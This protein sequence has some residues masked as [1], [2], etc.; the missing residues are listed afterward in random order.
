MQRLNT[1]S[2][3][4][5]QHENELSGSVRR[6]EAQH[7]QTVASLEKKLERTIES[8]N[9]LDNSLN[10]GPSNGAN[11]T[12]DGNVAM[13][14][15]ERLEELDKQRQRAQDAKFLI[16]CW[17]EVSEKGRLSTLEDVRR[18]GG[19]DGKVRCAHI[20]RQL[21]KL[22]QR[23]DDKPPGSSGGKNGMNGAPGDRT[24]KQQTREVIEKF[25]EM[26]EK[27]LL[28]QFD[29]HYRKQNFEGM[30]ECAVALRDFSD[31]ASV[32][33][34]FVNQHQFFI[35]RSQL[36]TE[37]VG[38]D[39]EILERLADPDAE[40]PGV[41][42]SLQSL[43]DE[44]RLVVQEESFIIKRAFPYYDE[45]LQ[46]FLQ[47][48]F[49]QSI[50]QRLEMVLE[51]ANSISS[52]AF[53]RTLHS[54]RS[55]IGALVEELKSHGLTEHP[56]P[57]S[58]A[59]VQVLDQQLEDMFVPYFVIAS[60]IE[61]ERRNLE[62]LYSSLLFK[63]TT[64][65]S[66]R[67]KLPTT[68]MGRLGERGKELMTSARDAYMDRLDST[69]LPPSQ[70]AML[71]RV[72]GLKAAD[73]DRKAEIEVSEEDGQLSLGNAKR[74]LK[75]LAEG[76]GRGL[77][78]SGGND[79]PKEAQVLLGLLLTHMGEIYLETA[80]V[81]TDELAVA[82]ESARTEPDLSYLVSLRTS[83][84]ILHLL[85]AS[86]TTMLL[87][88]AKP[89]LTIRRDIDKSTNASMSSLETKISTILHRSLD[90]ALVWVSKLLQ[91]Q[92]KT[93]F[94]PREEDM[95]KSFEMLQTPTCLSI[96][97]FL[98]K[99]ARFA[100]S[101][102]DGANLS[103][104]LADLALG[105]RSLLLEHFRKFTVSLAGGLIVSKDATKYVELVRAWPIASAS[106]SSAAAQGS[107]KKQQELE[108]EFERTG[109]M[110]VLVEVANLFVVGPEALREKLKPMPGMQGARSG[111]E[112]AELRRY[113]EQ[114]EDLRSVGMQAV[115]SSI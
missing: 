69:D 48:I 73:A 62:E 106:S 33:G 32:M 72:A 1:L 86:I 108:T 61:R 111:E 85:Q 49:Q 80:L 22:S 25:L 15:G 63:Y 3:D 57:A 83:I 90:T 100:T 54:A 84:A 9:K 21:L 112:T 53:L 107:V 19:S 77:E 114:R 20:A 24:S 74:M 59:I 16:H 95:A 40:P 18:M 104:F 98:S 46:R 42:P 34:L 47:R 31:G 75:W 45:V 92:K 105:L 29:D 50:Q 41:E 13:R 70:K 39:P 91:S 68:M 30:K 93:D 66:R 67:K 65:H 8:F 51:K 11:G 113:V 14:I 94:R 76:V 38:N 99:I 35:D 12:E 2:E 89:N 27:D 78:L 87:P 10:G 17:I 26:L 71:L 55:Y 88:L 7:N 115:L 4:L 82:Q 109:G 103:N 5:E 60:Y 43:V 36:I 102:L 52:L 64:Y 101:A 6:A 97:Q 79:V 58:P 28:K 81:A 23:L 110:D 37:E 44:V 96:F 56:E